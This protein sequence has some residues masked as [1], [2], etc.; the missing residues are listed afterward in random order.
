MPP[1][2]RGQPRTV[3]NIQILRLLAA[4]AVVFYHAR[5]AAVPIAGLPLLPVW[6]QPLPKMGF[7]GVDVFFVI[8]GAIMALT[9]RSAEPGPRAALRFG[10]LRFGRI[11]AGWWPFFLAYCAL[12]GWTG[13]LGDK[14]LWASLWLWPTHLGDYVVAVIWTLTYELYFYLLLAAMLL[15]PRRM[16]LWGMAL[17]GLAVVVCTLWSRQAGLFTPA[18]ALHASIWQL[19]L[20]SPLVAEFVAGYLLCHW[21]QRDPTRP[22]ASGLHRG[23]LLGGA[24]VLGVLAG[25]YHLR[26]AAYP[27]GLAGYFHAPERAL[28]LGGM[29]LCLVAWALRAPPPRSR[30]GRAL[31]AGGDASYALYLAHLLLLTL[32]YKL[33]GWLQLGDHGVL[34]A[35][36]YTLAVAAIFAA[37]IAHYRGIERP[38]HRLV[39][40]WVKRALPQAPDVALK[41]S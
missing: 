16:R 40:R 11:Y 34:L 41:N 31:V 29:A 12:L 39:R 26:I 4:A 27:G 24:V 17:V 1:P 25:G 7:A 19:F 8:S 15:L 6:L 13:Q 30:F 36:A 22:L 9:T 21:L 2:S 23:L 10:L 18:G 28:L 3:F 37:S 33:F 38:L 20:L 14:N 35:C 5:P 32:C